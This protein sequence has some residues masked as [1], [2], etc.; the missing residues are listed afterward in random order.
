MISRCNSTG[1]SERPSGVVSCHAIKCPSLAWWP[2]RDKCIDLLAWLRA[3][4][5]RRRTRDVDVSTLSVLMLWHCA[6]A[7][8]VAL[9]AADEPNLSRASHHGFLASSNMRR[10]HGDLGLRAVR[11]R[12][13]TLG[14]AGVKPPEL[15]LDWR[16]ISR[17]RSR[18]AARGSACCGLFARPASARKACL[19]GIGRRTG[20]AA[21]V[22]GA[23][24]FRV[25]ETNAFLALRNGSPLQTAVRAS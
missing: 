10:S 23:R 18:L 24:N 9:G 12:T 19:L 25:S 13:I 1:I 5:S 11:R 4:A 2:R 16:M 20:F 7:A 6:A 22:Q 21:A 8:R 15:Q 14:Q 3:G 17:S